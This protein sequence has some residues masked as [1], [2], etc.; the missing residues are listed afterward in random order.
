MDVYCP[1]CGRNCTGATVCPGCGWSDTVPP[2][3]EA[4]VQ[5][6]DETPTEPTA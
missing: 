1:C 6:E 2:V 4:P 3:E 5:V